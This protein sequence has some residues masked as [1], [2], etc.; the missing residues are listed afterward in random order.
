MIPFYWSV[1]N[2]N[3]VGY[4][5]ESG[6]THQFCLSI[7][8]SV[9]L[10]W[11]V[12]WSKGS[13]QTLFTDSDGHWNFFQLEQWPSSSINDVEWSPRGSGALCTY[14]SMRVVFHHFPNPHWRSSL[15]PKF[16]C[17]GN[18]WTMMH[19]DVPLMTYFRHHWRTSEGTIDDTLQGRLMTYFRDHW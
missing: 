6:V 8:V 2:F 9:G 17:H 3:G 1:D 5:S 12:K 4:F 14:W 15:V 18:F 19:H 16:I 7:D 13:P 10:R 11:T